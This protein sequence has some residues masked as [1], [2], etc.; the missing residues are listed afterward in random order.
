MKA[1]MGTI[2]SKAEVNQGA[3]RLHHMPQLDALRAFAVTAVIVCHLS[4]AGTGVLGYV[5]YS[6]VKIF[7]ALS[8][9]LI[10][11]ILLRARDAAET[12]RDKRIA[13]MGRFYARRFLRIFPV[14]YFVVG[15][16]FAINVES[17]RGI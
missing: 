17:V 7:F 13:A 2:P 5:A 15:L 1:A 3:E 4:G 11:G 8:G 14:Y 16:A 10:T 9:F 12:N 6:A